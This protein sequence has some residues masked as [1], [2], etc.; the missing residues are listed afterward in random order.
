MCDRQS[1]LI[2]GLLDL[3]ELER[4]LNLTTLESVRLCDI[5]PGVVS[6]YQPLAQEKGILLAYTVPNDLPAVRCVTGRLRQ[7]VINLLHN[8]IKF[9]P[10]GGQVSV[11]AFLGATSPREGIQKDLPLAGF[12]AIMST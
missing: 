4:N 10:N 8:S 6:T 5:V 7:I 11:R 1:S 12:K 3:V 9:T 2:T